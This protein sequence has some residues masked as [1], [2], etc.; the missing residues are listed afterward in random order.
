MRLGE[1]L[2]WSDHQI[3]EVVDSDFE[4]DFLDWKLV[5]LAGRTLA[6][7]HTLS[8]LTDGKFVLAATL[9]LPD[10]RIESAYISMYLPEREID[11][12]YL[13]RGTGIEHGRGTLTQGGQ[14]I[15]AVAIEKFGAYDQFYIPG[16]SEVGIRVLRDGLDCAKRKAPIAK[17]LAYI[18]RDEKR[19]AEAVEYFT[20]AIDSSDKVRKGDYFLFSERAKLFAYLND[21]AAADRDW[22]EVE[23]LAG[24]SVLKYERGF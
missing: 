18:L 23:R 8:G 12:H 19:Y 7:E 13:L 22:A 5:P 14:V 21:A 4:N 20:L 2:F 9:V 16:H 1:T 3:F 24:S 15:P 17:D 11:H 10:G 6:K